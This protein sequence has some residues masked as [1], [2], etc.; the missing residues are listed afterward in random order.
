[1]APLAL[2]G[3][4]LRLFVEG[5]A[6]GALARSVAIWTRHPGGAGGALA[7]RGR[8]STNPGSLEDGYTGGGRSR[9][10]S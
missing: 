10:G 9:D 4:G 6:G 3:P 8:A 2:S 5:G 1:M 7:S